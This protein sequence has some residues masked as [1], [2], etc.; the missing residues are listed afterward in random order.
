MR[1]IT[2]ALMAGIWAGAAQAATVTYVFEPE[3]GEFIDREYGDR[4]AIRALYDE[5]VQQ[6]ASEY[7]LCLAAGFTDCE[8]LFQFERYRVRASYAPN[9][10]MSFDDY[11]TLHTDLAGEAGDLALWQSGDLTVFVGSYGGFYP[12][13]Y[14]GRDPYFGF[15]TDG[16][17]AI[18]PSF[19]TLSIPEGQSFVSIDLYVDDE[20]I[21]W[22]SGRDIAP[23]FEGT[24]EFDPLFIGQTTIELN[25]WPLFPLGAQDFGVMRFANLVVD[26]GTIEIQPPE[27]SPVPLPASLWLMGLGLAGLGA[28]RRRQK[29]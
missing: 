11:Y 10:P 5:E 1:A 13:G 14:A 18:G 7:P 16:G 25:A 27:P 3:L 19:V 9:A 29:V 23:G 15:A 4:A 28:L 24:F 6:A 2:A 21:G 26:D 8:S 17:D 20:S 22:L 12:Y